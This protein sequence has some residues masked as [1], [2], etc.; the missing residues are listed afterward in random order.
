LAARAKS[1]LVLDRR[2]VGGQGKVH[3]GD[4][5]AENV[6]EV[7]GHGPGQLTQSGHFSSLDG[8]LEQLCKAGDIGEASCQALGGAVST[9]DRGYAGGQMSP[10]ALPVALGELKSLYLALLDHPLQYSLNSLTLFGRDEWQ[11]GG[12]DHLS[13]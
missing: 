11:D 6:V 3:A 10:A 7:V 8:F 12:A 13:G 4:Q 2:V 1:T 5:P 9:Y